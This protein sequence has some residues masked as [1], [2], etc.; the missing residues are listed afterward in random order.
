M[1]LLWCR[2]WWGIS[3]WLSS[4]TSRSDGVSFDVVKIVCWMICVLQQAWQAWA[5][6]QGGF[7]LGWVV[8]APSLDFQSKNPRSDLHW[9]YLAVTDF[10]SLM[11]A[12]FGV[13]LNFLRGE[14]P[15]DRNDVVYILF[16]FWRRRLKE[17]LVFSMGEPIGGGSSCYFEC[18]VGSLFSFKCVHRYTD[19]NIF[20]ILIILNYWFELFL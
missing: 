11:E 17:N 16:L 15:W 4:K 18:L 2:E 5:A 3:I 7:V 14:I 19:I 6:T 13:Y 12:L 10:I 20:H 8:W 9:L 1:R